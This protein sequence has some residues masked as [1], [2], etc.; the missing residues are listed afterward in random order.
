[1]TTAT[2]GTIAAIAER[3]SKGKGGHGDAAVAA[4]SA[5]DDGV[6]LDIGQDAE[7]IEHRIRD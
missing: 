2:S 1:M 6:L 5:R 3:R 7:E 4:P